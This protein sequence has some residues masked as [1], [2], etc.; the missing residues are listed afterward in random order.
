MY[1]L[2]L[3]VKVVIRD[4]KSDQMEIKDKDEAI[5]PRIS[6]LKDKL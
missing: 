3:Y 2:H 5:F 6:I 4:I 1:T